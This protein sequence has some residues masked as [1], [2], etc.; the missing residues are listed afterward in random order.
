MHYL[1]FLIEV[2]RLIFWASLDVML[3]LFVYWM[4]RAK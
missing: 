4:L 3:L 2:A 1:A